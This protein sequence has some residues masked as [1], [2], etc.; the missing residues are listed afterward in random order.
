ML[1][2]LELIVKMQGLDLRANELRK[3]IALLPKQIA[4]IEKVLVAHTRKVEADRALLGGNLKERKLRELEIQTQQAKAAKLK[5]Q[6]AAAKTNEQFRAFQNEIDYCDKE[7]KKSEDR[8]VELLEL[9]EPLAINVKA[10]EAALALEKAGVEKQNAS[11]RER[12]SADQKALDV[13]MAQ[14]RVLAESVTKPVLNHFE[15]LSKKYS[16]AAIADATRGR[17]TSC[18]LEIRPQLFQ[19]LRRG[20]K[21]FT[22]ENCGRM[23]HYNPP[24]SAE[25]PST[26][27]Y[28]LAP[29]GTRVDMS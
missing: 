20:E 5:D 29:D 2:D 4:E 28:R 8:I 27:T 9:S 18:N 25:P 24:I 17:C 16:G 3:E 1:A 19:D 6:M 11:A 15:R 12:T 21:L 7:I 22:C 14:R 10:A 23:L 26:G 13:I